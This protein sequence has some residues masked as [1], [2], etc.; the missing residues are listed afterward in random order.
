MWLY[1]VTDKAKKLG[2]FCSLINSVYGTICMYIHY[3]CLSSRDSEQT[4]KPF[5]YRELNV[6]GMQDPAIPLTQ[7]PPMTSAASQTG[8]YPMGVPSAVQPRPLPSQ[9]QT[10]DSFQRIN[11]EQPSSGGG[12]YMFYEDKDDLDMRSISMADGY[13]GSSSAFFQRQ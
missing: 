7:Y 5:G 4:K 3:Y 13:N 12:N 9:V 1:T 2:F 10:T 8:Y 11:F 6:Q